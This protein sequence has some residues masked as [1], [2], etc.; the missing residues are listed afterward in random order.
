[1]RDDRHSDS[2]YTDSSMYQ[3]I[4]IKATL[5]EPGNLQRVQQIITEQDSATRWAISRE[6]CEQFDFLDAKGQVR[7]HSC[8][9]ALTQLDRQGR[10][11][12]PPPPWNRL[13]SRSIR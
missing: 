10:I 11:S 6:V 7:G 12:L 8:L 9:A 4:P 3:P 5:L 1:M 2:M 13:R